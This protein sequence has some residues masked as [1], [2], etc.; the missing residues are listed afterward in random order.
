ME[1]GVSAVL[2][3]LNAESTAEPI[4]LKVSAAFFVCHCVH[5]RMR[6][7]SVCVRAHLGIC[8]WCVHVRLCFCVCCV[9]VSVC[10]LCFFVCL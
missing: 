5:M 7:C 3:L 9:S 8:E 2:S 4:A 1:G 6:V 10:V